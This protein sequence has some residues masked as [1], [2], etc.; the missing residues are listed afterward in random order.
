[1]TIWMKVTLDK[2]EFPLEIAD[3]PIALA[4][5]CGTT[6]GAVI[7]GVSKYKLGKAR[8]SFRKVVID[9]EEIE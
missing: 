9:E 3:N 5:K 7:S 6:R 8:S 1:M 2:Y 4:K